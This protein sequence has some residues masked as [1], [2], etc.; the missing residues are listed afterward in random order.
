MKQLKQAIEILSKAG[1]DS[2]DLD[3]RVL[4]EFVTGKNRAFFIA[5]S[6]YE[7][8]ADEKKHFDELLHRRANREPISQLVGKREFYGRDFLVS[9]DVL[10]PRP[11]TELIIDAVKKLYPA[12]SP[13]SVLD[14]G[15]GSGCILLTILQEY[16]NSRGLG[17]DIS[18]KA[19]AIAKQ[20]AYNLGVNNAEL[21]LS[22]WCENL[23]KQQKFNLIISNPPYIPQPE[24]A[25]LDK[26]LSFEPDLALFG[27]DDGLVAYRRIAQEIKSLNF[28]FAIFE[29]GINQE[30]EVIEIFKAAGLKY[31][32][33][34]KDL[35]NI[36]RTLV[37]K[38]NNKE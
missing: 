15:T 4:L 1:V 36:P 37:F 35:Q 19:L 31:V 21:I 28:D 6:E 7:L 24:K 32:E 12:N 30:K 26:D 8:A 25:T 23:D 34:L 14:L 38:K 11:E 13:I 27:G 5:H 29:I 2:P 10:T 33:T 20:N 9:Q 18:Q 22:E 17:V 16:P 3:A